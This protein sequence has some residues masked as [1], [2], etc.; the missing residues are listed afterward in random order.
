MKV[1]FIARH[2]TYFRNFE[3]VIGALADRGH[4]IHLAADREETLGGRELVDRLAARHPVHVTVG[5]TPILQW[6]RYR[7]LASALR[8]GLDYLRYS[9]PR[10]EATPK[11]RERAYERTPFLVLVLA[12]LPLRGLVTRVLEWLEQ[13]VPR[14]LGVDGFIRDQRANVLL[15]TPLIELGSPQLDYVRAA[16][17]L[18]IRSALCVWS[19]DHLSSKALIRV[20]PD[21][22]IVWNEVQRAEAERFHGIPPEQVIV[23]GAQCFDQWFDRAPARV[24]DVFCQRVGLPSSRPFLLYVCSALFKNSPSEAVFVL[25]WVDTILRSTDPRLREAAILV[26][27][28][29]QRLEE[30]TPEALASLAR[31]GNVMFWGSNPVDRESR[32]DY[33]DSMYHAAA[34]V[35]LNTSALVEAAIVDRPV[36]TILLPE[37]SDNQEGT[38]HFHHLLSVGNGFLNVSRSLDEHAGQLAQALAGGSLRPNRPFVEQFIRPRGVGTAATPVFVD[39]VEE[40]GSG[41]P[42]T[43]RPA[44]AW[45]LLLRPL[46][47]A[48][49]LAGRLPW[50]ER[51]YWNPIKRREWAH[52]VRAIW[53]KDVQRGAKRRDKAS[54]VARRM[55]QQAFVRMK[56]AAK[57]ALGAVGLIRP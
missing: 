7:R 6:G 51:I 30:W 18:G 1:L 57:Q 38:F 13:A 12:R 50:L 4:R 25:Q 22:V 32:A 40:L 54:R 31:A 44:P 14:Q 56:T 34:V 28:H 20:V 3:S 27:P 17:A 5:F 23:T 36:F 49:V 16:R 46:V 41:A 42:A 35:G 9:D 26:R 19:W 55:P 21:R 48:L 11:I 37:F 45:L 33:F 39:A 2:F 43:P 8:I 10:Y 24:R 15:I 53:T 29:P 47:Y 52:N